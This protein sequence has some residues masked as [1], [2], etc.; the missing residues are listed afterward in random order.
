M[1]KSSCSY[2]KNSVSI[3]STVSSPRGE[4]D[5]DSLLTRYKIISEPFEIRRETENANVTN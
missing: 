2:K 4:R 3:R 5:Q 1:T